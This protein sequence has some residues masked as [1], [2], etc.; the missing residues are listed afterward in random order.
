MDEVEGV[1]H[2]SSAGLA[3]N[4]QTGQRSASSE[5]WTLLQ[6]FPSDNGK[7]PAP[8][9]DSFLI[10]GGLALTYKKDM[11]AYSRFLL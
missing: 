11:C 8:A 9:A 1:I 3:F 2:G 7:A 5:C 4:V 10:A 6:S